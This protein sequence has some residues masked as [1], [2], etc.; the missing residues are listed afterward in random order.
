MKYVI[1]FLL[2]TMSVLSIGCSGPVPN[3]NEQTNRDAYDRANNAA[4][5]AIQTLDSDTKN[6]KTTTIGN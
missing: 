5:T 1:N 6:M 3:C 4:Q 2:V